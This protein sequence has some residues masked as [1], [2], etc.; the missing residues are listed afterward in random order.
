MHL[1][2]FPSCSAPT[3]KAQWYL[4]HT[5]ELLIYATAIRT[6][7]YILAVVAYVRESPQTLSKWRCWCDNPC[8]LPA[9]NT[10][11]LVRILVIMRHTF[12]ISSLLIC[13][14]SCGYAINVDAVCQV[15]GLVYLRCIAAR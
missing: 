6:G 10:L 5:I 13:C 11:S 8:L 2:Q 12:L 14:A 3:R 1:G 15:D 9:R 7:E 4:S